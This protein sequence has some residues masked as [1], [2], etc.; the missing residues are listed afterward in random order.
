M[1]VVIGAQRYVS[2]EKRIRL[3][4]HKALLLEELLEEMM[5]EALNKAGVLAVK[6][7]MAM[8]D[9]GETIL[10]SLEIPRTQ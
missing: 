9:E 8:G 7:K 10:A 3:Q 1:K 4:V 6:P 2:H 5:D